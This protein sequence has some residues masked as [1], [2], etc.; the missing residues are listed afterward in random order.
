L[1]SISQQR[2]RLTPAV[3]ARLLLGVA[4]DEPHGEIVDGVASAVGIELQGS[5]VAALRKLVQRVGRRL[6][7]RMRARVIVSFTEERVKKKVVMPTFS[8]S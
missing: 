5:G 2:H 6:S 1:P 4:I 3:L 7:R 8:A